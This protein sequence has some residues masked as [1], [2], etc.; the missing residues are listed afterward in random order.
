M[1]KGYLIGHITVT[2]PDAYQEYVRRDTPVLEA[3]GGRFIVRGGASEVREGAFKDR[4][5]VIEF[6]SL[7]AARTAYEDPAYQQIAGI[8]WDNADSDI[9]LVEGTE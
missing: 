6:P 5:V 9:L 2:N 3:H 7:D 1:P 4:H 8:R